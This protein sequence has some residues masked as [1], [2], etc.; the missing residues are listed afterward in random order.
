LFPSQ[1]LLPHFFLSAIRP[2][3]T[4]TTTTDVQ[5]HQ[6]QASFFQLRQGDSLL[7]NSCF[8]GTD[9]MHHLFVY[10]LLFVVCCGLLWFI[11]VCCYLLLFVVVVRCCGGKNDHRAERRGGV[12]ALEECIG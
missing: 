6:H 12:H 5:L 11:V 4:T 9:S 2:D 10:C 8:C 1:H 3:A 7:L